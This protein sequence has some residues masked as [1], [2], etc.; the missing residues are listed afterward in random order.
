MITIEIYSVLCYNTSNYEII[1]VLLVFKNK[2]AKSVQ[3]P[4]GV[5]ASTQSHLDIAE[6]R[7]NILVL[8]DGSVRGVFRVSSVNFDLKS[9]QEQNALIYG[10]QGFLNTLEF[11][12]QIQ[13]RSRKMDIDLYLEKLMVKAQQELNRRLQD[14]MYDYIEF[15]KK[16]VDMAD[17]MKK[18]FYVVVPNDAFDPMKAVSP[19][20]KLLEMFHK[21]DS[22]ADF[23]KRTKDFTSLKKGLDQRM[24]V[25]KSGL[26]NMGLSSEQLTTYQLVELF[27]QSYNPK[28][29]QVQKMK[30]IDQLSVEQLNY[31]A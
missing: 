26:E 18:D 6:I 16:L 10:Y 22:R 7:D 12:V 9:E 24:H 1:N 3:K 8:K 14:Q 17:I 11:P 4:K 19:I 2:N 29:S 21:N 13:I 31:E 28:T 23:A 15:V 27:Y 5:M 25:V 20:K 30:G